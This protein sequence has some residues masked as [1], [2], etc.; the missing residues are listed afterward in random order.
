[1]SKYKLG[2]GDRIEI[3]VFDEAELS[4]VTLLGDTGI[5]N[6]PFLGELKLTGI[7]VKQVAEKITKGL[8][9]PYLVNPSVQVSV[10]EYRPFFIDG[11][12]NDPGGYPYQPGLNISKAVALAGGFTERAS[13]TSIYITRASDKKVKKIKVSL[14]DPIYPG[15]ILDIEESFF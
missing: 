13:K 12:V 3:S 10:V 6:Y 9:G 15:D 11:E 2:S 1:M 14:N 8:K 4:I 7:T 5:I